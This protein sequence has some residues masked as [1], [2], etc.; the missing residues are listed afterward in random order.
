MADTEESRTEQNT[1]GIPGEVNEKSG[2]AQE[3]GT[4][5]GC[6]IKTCIQNVMVRRCQIYRKS[7]KD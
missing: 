4:G 6:E 2:N 3:K 5:G 1:W 7:S